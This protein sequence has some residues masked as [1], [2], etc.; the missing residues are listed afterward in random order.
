MTFCSAHG[1]NDSSHLS[2]LIKRGGGVSDENKL[3][4]KPFH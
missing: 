1:R 4:E 3:K 2:D